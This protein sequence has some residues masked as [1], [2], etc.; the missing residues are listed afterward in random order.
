MQFRPLSFS[1]ATVMVLCMQLV[2]VSAAP[3]PLFPPALVAPTVVVAV[4]DP[5][6][7]FS[8]TTPCQIQIATPPRRRA[9]PLP[10]I[11]RRWVAPPS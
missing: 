3:T 4:Q 9:G 5:A 1:L 6:G 8:S 11:Q 7:C 10:A 2:T